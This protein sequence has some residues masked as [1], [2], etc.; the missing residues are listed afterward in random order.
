VA[1]R[2]GTGEWLLMLVGGVHS[3][4]ERNTT[5]LLERI[6]DQLL[7]DP[8]SVHPR[9]TWL[10]IPALNPDG[11]AQG[12]TLAGRFNANGVDLN[13]NWGCGWQSEAFFREMR[14]SAGSA[15][16]SEP[17]TLALGG[18]IQQ[19][20]PRAVLFYHAAANGVFG[21]QCDNDVSADLVRVYGEASQYPYGGTFSSYPIT[22]TAPNWVAS[23]GIPA[24]DV[25]LATASD[26]EF[27]RN[28]RAL[29]AVQAWIVGQAP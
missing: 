12:E 26:P 1:Y 11:M 21:G 17:E 23:L 29:L 9:M 20:Q 6:R 7:A 25:E 10:L 28:W 14:V 4:Y 5:A 2:F 19:T 13:R 8:A 16:F 15:P 27:V 3:G 18:L 22:G 24:A